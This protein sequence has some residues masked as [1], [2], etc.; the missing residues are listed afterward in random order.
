MPD[1][2]IH[3]MLPAS[4]IEVRDD[5]RGFDLDAVYTFLST[6]SP[7]ARTV[8]R[9]TFARAIEHSLCFGAFS[10][11]LH[12]GGVQLGFARVVTDRATFAFLCDVFT[13]PPYRGCGVAGAM[14]AAIDAHP[15][16]AGLG[17]RLLFTREAHG[18]YARFGYRP[19]ATP[20]RV[21]EI[22]H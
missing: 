18:L 4:S 6:R 1:L 10:R 3:A 9:A 14:L 12:A 2:T 8:S 15:A 5:P 17:H 16:L 7:C 21:M 11:A 22:R 19:T 13:F 20:E